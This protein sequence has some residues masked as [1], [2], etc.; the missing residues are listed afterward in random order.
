MRRRATFAAAAA[1]SPS[2]PPFRR[3]HGH[4]AA[5]R[6]AHHRS[7]SRSVSPRGLAISRCCCHLVATVTSHR[8][9]AARSAEEQAAAKPL[10]LK[11]LGP[12]LSLL[13][14]ETRRRRRAATALLVTRGSSRIGRARL[15]WALR[16]ASGRVSVLGASARTLSVLLQ[17]RPAAPSHPPA[18]SAPR[19]SPESEHQPSKQPTLPTASAAG[20]RGARPERPCGALG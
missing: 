4:F 2:P 13:F 19:R 18:S 1:P 16:R 15:A 11:L 8:F 5:P 12:L 14:G 7:V 6:P 17:V 10:L 3:R 9:S 20:R